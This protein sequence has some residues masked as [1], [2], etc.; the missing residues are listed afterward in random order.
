MTRRMG[1]WAVIAACYYSV[2]VSDYYLVNRR[3]DL[4]VTTASR[5]EEPPCVVV[6]VRR[7]I[8]ISTH[9]HALLP[10]SLQYY[11]Y[12]YVNSRPISQL[13]TAIA[14]CRFGQRALGAC[15]YKLL[16]VIVYI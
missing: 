12:H 10:W 3:R 1:K 4:S 15:E 2:T 16:Q 11:H 13:V 8:T 9:K 6:V 5:E 14:G 7:V